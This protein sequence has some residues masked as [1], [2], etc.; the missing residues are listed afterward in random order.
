M[1][2]KILGDDPFRKGQAPAKPPKASAPQKKTKRAPSRKTTAPKK[3]SPVAA[4]ETVAATATVTSVA[5]AADAPPIDAAP[6]S[7]RWWR[8]RQLQLAR[9]EDA[10][11]IARGAEDA[12]RFG[13]DPGLSGRAEPIVDFVYRALMRVS[14]RGLGHVPETGRAILVAR[15]RRAPATGLRRAALARLARAG[16][17]TSLNDPLDAAIIAHAIRTEHVAHREVRPLVRPARLYTP[18]I[19]SLLRRLGG[20]PADTHDLARLLDDDRLALAFV[21]D[22][23]G[24]GIDLATL[25]CLALLTGAPLIPVV[26]AS[27]RPQGRFGLFRGPG[28]TALAFGT[29]LFPGAEFGPEGAEDA[30]IVGR[31]ASELSTQ[32][33]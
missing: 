15:R 10:A 7:W 21:D 11:F 3:A 16:L 19:G 1:G 9:S 13:R 4:T 25:V 12:D 8:Y 14:V 20:V 33:V 18:F 31:V 17:P 23:R 30:S 28:L 27:S 2:K 5:L 24:A 29:P 26:I 22:E 6:G 32:L